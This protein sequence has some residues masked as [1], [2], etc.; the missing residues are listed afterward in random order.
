MEWWTK[1]RV[2]Q[3]QAGLSKRALCRGAGISW[4]TLEKVLGHPEPPGY[5]RAAPYPE[6]PGYR[7]A[8]PYPEPPGYRRAAPYAEPKLGPFVE[9]IQEILASDKSLPKKQR[10]TAQRIFERLAE[11]GY[12]GGYTQVREK[13]AQLRRLSGE[14]F[15]PLRHDPGTAQMDMRM[16]ASAGAGLSEPRRKTAE[17]LLL[18]DGAAVLG[19]D[20]RAGLRSC[21]DG[22]V[23]G[24]PSAGLRVLLRGEPA[25]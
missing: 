4:K 16:L 15:I 1:L 17:G 6:P 20:V 3:A 24:V 23:L 18:R 2:R 21:A 12:T 8:A 5:R 19:R 22:D 14:V 11:E 10:H 9:R 7:R 13:G 25:Q